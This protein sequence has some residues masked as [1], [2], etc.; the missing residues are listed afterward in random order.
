MSADQTY[1]T[2][3]LSLLRAGKNELEALQRSIS[4]GIVNAGIGHR[5]MHGEEAFQRRL[6]DARAESEALGEDPPDVDPWDASPDAV[7]EAQVGASI[8]GVQGGCRVADAITHRQHD[9]P[10]AVF[11]RLR[12]DW[13][14]NALHTA[15]QAAGEDEETHDDA[16]ERK[17]LT[18]REFRVLAAILSARV[19]SYGFV[20]LGWESIQARACGYHTK[21]LL[22]AGK[23]ALPAHCQPLSRDVIR[24]TLDKLEALG[25]FARCRYSTGGRGGLMAYSFRHPGREGLVQS[26]RQWAADNRAFQAKVAALRAE[27]LAAFS[28]PVVKP[29]PQPRTAP[30]GLPLHQSRTTLQLPSQPLSRAP[31]PALPPPPSPPRPALYSAPGAVPKH[32]LEPPPCRYP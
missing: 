18:W 2:V 16:A 17:P 31:A 28:Q 25:F 21:E 4:C 9:Q 14:W 23:A 13:M 15:S 19:N 5:R 26:I 20:F 24:A 27:D 12:S 22:Q 32:P 6:A 10:G 3:P 8:V 11:F 29:Q 1:F 30:H 7:E